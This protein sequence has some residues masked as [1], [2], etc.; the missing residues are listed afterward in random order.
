MH[1]AQLHGLTSTLIYKLYCYNAEVLCL[2]SVSM[3]M[4]LFSLKNQSEFTHRISEV[5]R[6]KNLKK[7]RE[8]FAGTLVIKDP[9]SVCHTV[10]GH[11][12]HGA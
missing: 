5:Y 4:L 8:G 12:H 3:N 6:N 11:G 9:F 10:S 7:N 1:C 2:H